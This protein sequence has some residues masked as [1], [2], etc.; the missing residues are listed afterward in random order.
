VTTS[1]STPARGRRR[2]R[3][4]PQDPDPPRDS[5]APRD[6][7]AKPGSDAPRDSERPRQPGRPRH[8]RTDEAI[9]AATFRQLVDVGYG[10]L[11]VESVAAAAGVAKTTI[12][13]RYPTKRDLAIAALSVELPFP[14]L[15]S[16]IDT[17]SGLRSVIALIAHAMVDTGAIRI[18][19]SLLV[20]SNRDPDPFAV[21]RQRL[22]E[23][24]RALVVELLRRGIERGE[25]RPD[26]D[27]LIVTEMMAGAIFAHH[28]ILGGSTTNAWLDGLT[29]HLWAMVRSDVGRSSRAGSRARMA[30]PPAARSGRGR[31]ASGR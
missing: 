31:S 19:G 27:P 5:D 14:E 9:L 17:R 20:E 15:P 23:P 18:L 22:L 25:V 24:R 13:R 7:E 30:A 3:E 8:P 2:E 4:P 26:A 28:A 21:F 29:D 11:S 16:D 6:S 12:Y 1:P 10:S